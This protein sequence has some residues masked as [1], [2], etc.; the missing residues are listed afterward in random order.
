MQSDGVKGT[1]TI[2]GHAEQSTPF[3]LD[4][5]NNRDSSY[6]SVCRLSFSV[7]TYVYWSLVSDHVLFWPR[8]RTLQVY[9]VGLS[10]LLKP[11][12]HHMSCPNRILHGCFTS[13]NPR[14]IVWLCR[15]RLHLVLDSQ[16]LIRR[17]EISLYMG[18]RC[19]K[20]WEHQ[21]WYE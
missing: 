5:Q 1:R 19:T 7:L 18:F 21:T 9:I 4:D 20:S 8:T 13:P 17:I 3:R 16:T 6:I 14:G 11:C 15:T 10:V 2:K 12:L